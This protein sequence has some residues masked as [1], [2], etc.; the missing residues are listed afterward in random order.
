MNFT[1][2]PWNG[3]RANTG[4]Q[5]PTETKT[6]PL[7]K[8]ATGTGRHNQRYSADGHY[9]YTEDDGRWRVRDMVADVLIWDEKFDPMH[10]GFTSLV[11]TRRFTAAR[12]QVTPV[13]DQPPPSR[14]VDLALAA[15]RRPDIEKD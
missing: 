15:V 8:L 14:A 10:M 2:L 6:L 3:G 9:R 7:T 1:V 4:R 13:A 5:L 12:D 11:E